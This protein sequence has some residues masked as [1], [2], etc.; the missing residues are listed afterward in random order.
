M[1]CWSRPEGFADPSAAVR[2]TARRDE[3][4]RRTLYEAL[5]PFAALGMTREIAGTG[6][7]FNLIVNDNDGK[8]REGYLAA[9]PGMGTGEDPSLW[10]VLQLE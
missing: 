4:N 7:R 1:F 6:F 5:L 10:K 3:K 2:A 9:A 8:L